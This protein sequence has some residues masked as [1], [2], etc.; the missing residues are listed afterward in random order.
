MVGVWSVI[1]CA[2]TA[3]G[4]LSGLCFANTFVLQLICELADICE[5]AMFSGCLE[6]SLK[7]SLLF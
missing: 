5:F 3:K 1:Q 7:G 6:T 4:E 2:C